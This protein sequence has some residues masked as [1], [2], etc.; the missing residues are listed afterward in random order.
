MTQWGQHP[1]P[2]HT[3]VHLSDTH[4]R[5]GG[6]ALYDAVDTEGNARLAMERLVASGIRA[7]A[8]VFT[9]DIAE[10]G[11]DDAYARVRAIVEPAAARLGAEVVWVMGNHDLRPAFR[12]RLLD[13]GGRSERDPVDY[14]RHVG[15]LRIIALDTTVPGW[16]HGE[17]TD[18]QL[19]W[20]REQ[21]RVS[22]EHGSLLA[23]HHPPIPTSLLPMQLLELDHQHRLAAVLAGTDVR[24]ILGGHLHYATHSLL[25]GIPVSVAAA[26]CYTM[27]LLEPEGGLCGM[28]GGQS[29]NL[30]Q[31]YPD[32]VVHSVVPLQ[33]APAVTAFTGEFL[34]R[35][36]EL[37]TDQRRELFS[38]K[39]DADG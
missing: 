35:L 30:V 11:E 15:G 7:D 32:R 17:L 6:A 18:N 19:D 38:R 22:A 5:A 13:E 21:L 29:L 20:L 9:G 3:I 24:A 12:H 39:P 33:R 23:L 2:T 36:E 34:D 28:N 26:S 1:E 16:H 37:G 10:H 27:D 4:L 25:A 14:V 31:L 8:L